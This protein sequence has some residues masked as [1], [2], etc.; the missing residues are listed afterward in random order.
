MSKRRGLGK[1]L[2]ALIPVPAKG[3]ADN[4]GIKEICID[5]VKP[6]GRQ[7]R[8]IFNEEKLAELATSIKK[9][10]VIQPVVVRPLKESGY[11]LIA[12]ER[13]WRACK[14]LGYKKIPAIVK[15]YMDMEAAA[16]S[17]IENVQREDLNPL[18]EALA[19]HYL[20]ND[21][22]LTQEEVSKRVGKSRPF[23]AN[24]IRLLGLPDEIKEMLV[25][26]QLNAGHA[27]ALLVIRDTGKQLA[28]AGKIAG[29]QMSVRQAEK[30]AKDIEGKKEATK[31]NKVP[32]SQY[33][34]QAEAILKNFVDAKVRIKRTDGGGGKLEIRFT[35][36]ADLKRIIDIFISDKLTPERKT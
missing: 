6:S 24:M 18:E 17:L 27:R 11:E 4:E 28:A 14:I 22:G 8:K 1:G 5:E 16:V 29:R 21:H 13:R 31:K 25:G 3:D 15:E 19:Y 9:H 26:G 35:N 23:V 2:Q 36:E 20:I 10:G 34:D 32:R 7:A 30:L 12:G 33:I